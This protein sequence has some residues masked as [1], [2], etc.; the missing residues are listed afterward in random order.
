MGQYSL[1]DSAMASLHPSDK[2]SLPDTMQ[3]SILVEQIG[4]D[5]SWSREQVKE[6]IAILEKNRLFLVRDLRA[7]S[8]HSWSVIE[9]LPLV[10][11][12]LRQAINDQTEKKKDK[13]NKKKNKKKER[14]GLFDP[15]PPEVM[16]DA[17][18]DD[19]ETI[20][21][22]I[23]N[24]SIDMGKDL[25]PSSSPPLD[26]FD[27]HKKSVSF[28]NQAGLIPALDSLDETTSS[29]SEEDMVKTKQRGPIKYMSQERLHGGL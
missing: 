11:D 17:L 6:D 16:T 15:V 7:L 5:R 22:T 19:P 10:R 8:E 12:L 3:T 26:Q 2:T 18:M 21:N 25:L 23:R 13:K 14:D 24:G 20:R 9:T 27:N 29:S 4:K 1:F 28:A